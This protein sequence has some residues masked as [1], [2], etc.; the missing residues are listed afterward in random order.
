MISPENELEDFSAWERGK[1]LRSIINTSAWEI[2]CDTLKAYADKAVEDL[3]RIPA[4]DND[5][6]LAAHAA[7]SAA[8]Q[9]VRNFKEDVETAVENSYRIPESLKPIAALG[10]Q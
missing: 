1:E 3:L 10:Q 4:G 2:L 5:R 6:V 7:A 9:I 8:A